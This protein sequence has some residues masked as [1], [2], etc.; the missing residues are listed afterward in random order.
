MAREP[1]RLEL[2]AWVRLARGFRRENELRRA[3]FV[4]KQFF[5]G[6]GVFATASAGIAWRDQNCRPEVQPLSQPRR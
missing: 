4:A 1:S 6:V 3:S 2:I 5:V